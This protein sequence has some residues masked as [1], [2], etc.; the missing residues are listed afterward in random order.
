[1]IDIASRRVQIVGSTPHPD[2]AF[3]RQIPRV[4]T[5]ADEGLLIDHRV[6]ICDRDRK[7]SGP[8]CAT[9]DDAGIRVV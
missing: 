1:M 9:T 2:A 8:V 5:A 3:M 7:W 4:L 6:L